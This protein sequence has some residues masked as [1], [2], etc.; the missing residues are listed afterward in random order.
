MCYFF[1]GDKVKKKKLFYILIAIVLGFILAEAIYGD[2]KRGLED[3]YTAYLIQIGSFSEDDEVNP[4]DYLVIKEDGRYNVYAGITTK[5]T[6]ATKIKNL[7]EKENV[8][9][10]IKPIVIDNVEFISDLEQFDVLLSEVDE[11]D[12]LISINDV[13]ISKYEEIILGK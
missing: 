9:T 6:N 13:I 8:N 2:Y 10:Y 1:Y 5:L 11:K 4:K 3:N 7:Y 12:S